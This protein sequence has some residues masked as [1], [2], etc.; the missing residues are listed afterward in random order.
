MLLNM[1]A[2]AESGEQVTIRVAPDQISLNSPEAT[3]QLLVFEAEADGAERDVSR[4]ARYK[5]QTEG[6]VEIST[7]GR[8][9]PLQDGETEIMVTV[10]EREIIAPVIVR[11]IT[12]AEP[13]S[14]RHFLV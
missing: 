8:I 9:M 5:V 7:A 3:D 4:E 12:H 13:V 14:F 2:W 1:A 6:I 11:G 10:G